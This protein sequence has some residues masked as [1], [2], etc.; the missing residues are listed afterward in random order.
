MYHL[1]VLMC[2]TSVQLSQPTKMKTLHSWL[3]SGCVCGWL[4]RLVF[5]PSWRFSGSQSP[6]L[7][8]VPGECCRRFPRMISRFLLLHCLLAGL[9]HQLGLKKR[10]FIWRPR[11]LLTCRMKIYCIWEGW[12]RGL[13]CMLLN[14]QCRVNGSDLG[15]FPLMFVDI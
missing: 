9:P 15:L 2:T 12:R 10:P 6:A 13:V 3:D 1:S 5:P 11:R 7:E 8:S 4:V 14:S